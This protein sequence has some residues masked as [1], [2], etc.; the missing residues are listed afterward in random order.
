MK[1]P[2]KKT[3]VRKVHPVE[4][5]S[6][7][8]D[9]D[10]HLFREGK[11]FNL[12]EKF[13]SHL[14]EKEQIPGTYFSVWAPNAEYVSVVGDFNGW[15]KDLHPLNV[16]WDESGIWEGWIPYVGR[17]DNYRYFIRSQIGGTEM[18]KCDP[19]GCYHNQPPLPSTKIH[20]TWYEWKDEKWM[21]LRKEKNKLGAPISVYEMHLGSWRRSPNDP[22][23]VLGYRDLANELVPYLKYMGYTHVEFLPLMEHPFYGSWGYQV[24]G[25]F[26]SCSRYGYPQDLMHLIDELHRNDIGVFLDWVPSHFPGDAHGLIDFDGTSLYEHEDLRKGFHPDWNSYIFNYGRNEVKSFLISNA[27]FWLDRYH[28]DGLRVDAVASMLYL[29][30]SRKAGE[31]VPNEFGGREN[32]EAIA[33]LKQFNEQVY[34]AYPDVQTIA[35]ESTAH[36]KVT[37]PTYDG[38]LG[39]GMKWMMGWM[40]DTLK[41]FAMDPIY[42]KFH[43]NLLTFSIMYAFSEKFMLPFSH[44]EVVHLKRSMLNKMP[45]DEWQKFANLRAL[46]GYMYAHPG[47]KLMFMGSEFGQ[48]HEWA[49]DQSLDWH[50]AAHAANKGLEWWVHDLNHVYKTEPALYQKNFSPDGFEWIEVNDSENSVLGFVRKGNNKGDMILFAANLTPVPRPGY[51]FGVPLKGKW[52]EILNSDDLRYY[53][54]GN[55]LNGERK[56]EPVAED[57]RD[58]SI[59]INVPPL[60]AVFMKF[61]KPK[62]KT[63]PV[64]KAAANHKG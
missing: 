62:K 45:G 33:F 61:V 4:T 44:D 48:E 55:H 13:G 16:R 37:A 2:K 43:H 3:V 22:D 19:F 29:D 41:Y 12:Y 28:A 26:A 25:Y 32:L 18:E 10:V 30:Y 27:M 63:T 9:Y 49:H 35:E 52:K 20:D 51:R 31:W 64:K 60:G 47:A 59:T 1:K 23:K 53:G 39:F 14:V 8:T 58:H 46:Y 7:F 42:R 36:P 38:G 21:K 6:L 17:G 50:L 40:N 34:L 54:T 57:G 56:S 5:H 24:T 11:H 15:N